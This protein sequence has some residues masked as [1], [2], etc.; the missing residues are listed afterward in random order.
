MYEKNLIIDNGSYEIKFGPA[1]NELPLRALNSLT[2]DKYSH[3]H[4]SNQVKQM[5]DISG[6]LI[7]RPH[8]LGQLVSWELEREI[9]DYLLYNEDEFKWNLKHDDDTKDYNLVASETCMTIPEL[10]KNMDQVIFEEYEF[11]SMFKGPVAQFIPFYK[12][13]YD[14]YNYTENQ[15]NSYRDFQLVIDSGFNCTWIIPMLKGVPYYKAVKKLDIG[16]RF[17]SGLLKETISFRHYNVM[18]ETILVNNIKEKC[19]FVPPESYFASFHD[20]ESTKVEYVLPDFLTSFIGYVK[21]PEEML[22]KGSQSLTLT[23]EL[24]SVPETFFHPE[25]SQILK[26]GIIETI[27]ESVNMCPEVV[28]PLLIANV[29]CTGGNFN[30]PNF[31]GRLQIELQRQCPADWNCRVHLPNCPDT[32]IH[33]WQSMLHFSQTDQFR[34]SRVTREEY[35]EHGLDW[36]T[37]NRFGFQKWL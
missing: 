35:L 18:D 3:Y 31:H 28:R 19:I 20:K 32:A 1:N 33:G 17:L 11:K 7:R 23:D 27:L 30:I 25:I 16:G 14:E 2:K 22:S 21:S 24:F 8:E 34:S 36:C 26:P 5:R 6:A 4:L 9:W 15:T 10:S 12:G 37:K 13:S 29:I